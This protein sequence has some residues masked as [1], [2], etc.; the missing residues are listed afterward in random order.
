MQGKRRSVFTLRVHSR[1]RRLDLAA[2]LSQIL[3]GLIK[4]RRCQ[5]EYLYTNG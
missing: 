1:F 3:S 5:D 4:S 2:M